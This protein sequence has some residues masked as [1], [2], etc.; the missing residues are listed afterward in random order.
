MA[1]LRSN[2]RITADD[3]FQDVRHLVFGTAGS[4]L[5]WQPGDALAILPRQPTAAVHAL[6]QRLG[7]PTSAKV[8]IQPADA[9]IHRTQLSCIE[10]IPPPPTPPPPQNHPPLPSTPSDQENVCASIF[11]WLPIHLAAGYT[12]IAAEAGSACICHT[13]I[14]ACRRIYEP[15]LVVRH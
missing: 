8:R 14:I 10:V 2:D 9:S 11:G 12:W 4:G 13:L 3:H 7:L 1:P 6:L 15:Q 5:E